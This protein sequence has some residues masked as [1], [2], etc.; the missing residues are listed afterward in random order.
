MNLSWRPVDTVAGR[1]ACA[2]L[3]TL[4]GT[5]ALIGAFVAFAGSWGMPPF[6]ETGL[7]QR[8]SDVIRIVE[9]AP[10]E[11]RPA[12]ADAAGSRIFSID[13]Y[14]AGSAMAQA[15]DA[16]GDLAVKEKSV[17]KALGDSAM[18]VRD[19]AATTPISQSADLHYDRVRHPN[20]L[21]L[22]VKLRDASWLVFT[23]F[24]RSWG[25]RRPERIALLVT[26]FIASSAVVTALAAR[27]LARPIQHFAAAARRFGADPK[28]PPM[29]PSGPRELRDAAH[30]FNAMQAQ[31]QKFLADRTTMLAAISHDLRTPLTRMRLRGE[32]IDDEA[33]QARLFRDVD[34]MNA[35]IDAALAFFRDDVRVEEVT[36]FDIAELARSI[37]ED[38][39]DQ[40]IAVS[41]VGPGHVGYVGRPFALKRALTNLVD[42][43]TRYASATEID[44]AREPGGVAISVRDRGP[45]IPAESIE[46]VFAPFYR[47]E[48]SRHRATGGVG[49]G[50][51]AA[52]AIAR[53][54][55]GDIVLRNRQHG[56]LE[57]VLRLPVAT[58]RGL[59]P[60]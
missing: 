59:V 51:A 55:G 48:T 3:L 7:L 45:G 39:G 31:I 16:N 30:S 1:F 15:F 18:V 36:A 5:A 32:L 8:A 33:Q 27:R 28:A 20:A 17:R 53:D 43:A 44:V 41:Y 10:A 60:T 12:I 40:A 19:F 22:A 6:E 29:A 34:E 58:C 23:A 11:L 35:M 13:W 57:A 4:G 54:H 37:A 38:F 42:N 14:G 52:Q 9:A 49:L 47:L 46:R 21:F 24:D 56:G 50:L 26:F 25:L 2:I